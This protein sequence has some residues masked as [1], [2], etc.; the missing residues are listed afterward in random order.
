MK[1]KLLAVGSRVEYIERGARAIHV[2][3]QGTIVD[4]FD[5]GDRGRDI[6][7]CDIGVDWDRSDPQRH[8]CLGCARMNHGWWVRPREIKLIF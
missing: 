1:F 5:M 7:E 4:I 8:N 2:G 3:E 6:E